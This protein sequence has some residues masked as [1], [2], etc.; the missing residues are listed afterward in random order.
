VILIDNQ[1]HIDTRVPS[2]SQTYMHC[3]GTKAYVEELQQ[4]HQSH[5]TGPAQEWGARQFQFPPS[6]A[7]GRNWH[8]PRELQCMHQIGAC[9]CLG[10]SSVSSPHSSNYR[11]RKLWYSEKFGGRRSWS[12]SKSKGFFF[13]MWEKWNHGTQIGSG[14][15]V[16]LILELR[17]HAKKTKRSRSWWVDKIRRGHRKQ[18]S[19]FRI[20]N[21]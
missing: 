1:E 8:S 9:R 20:V 21:A 16:I 18:Q 10:L 7:G 2:L 12:Y 3:I 15:S 17:K 4:T 13:F 14:F 5:T 11:H 6:A 19:P